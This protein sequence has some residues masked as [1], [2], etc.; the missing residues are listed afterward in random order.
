MKTIG[1]F[2]VVAGFLRIVLIK[3]YMN[4]V[5]FKFCFVC[6]FCFVF[7]LFY[8]I[9]LKIFRTVFFIS[10]LLFFNI[11]FSLFNFE[12]CFLSF[13]FSPFLVHE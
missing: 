8:F 7:S 11:F 6:V 9:F 10:Y 2:A 13:I 1:R 3:V 4:K 5:G 12:Y